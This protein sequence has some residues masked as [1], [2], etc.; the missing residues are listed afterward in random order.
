MNKKCSMIQ[1]KVTV[2]QLDDDVSLGRTGLGKFPC[3]SCNLIAL[4][5][6]F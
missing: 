3:H 1:Q 5:I 4:M 2:S 6:R